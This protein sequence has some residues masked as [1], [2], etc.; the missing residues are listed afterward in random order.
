MFDHK[1]SQ[2]TADEQLNFVLPF[3]L[4]NY[5]LNFV[6][7]FLLLNMIGDCS[8]KQSKEIF[9]KIGFTEQEKRSVRYFILIHP[10]S[11]VNSPRCISAQQGMP[12]SISI[13]KGMS[14]TIS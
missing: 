6:L 5:E 7:P 1:I 4:L 10:A 12:S 9:V 3:L 13:S 14:M 2:E 8:I 11:N